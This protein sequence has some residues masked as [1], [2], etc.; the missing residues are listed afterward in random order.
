[1][2]QIPPRVSER[3]ARERASRSDAPPARARVLRARLRIKSCVL[4]VARCKFCA[5]VLMR[6]RVL[7]IVFASKVELWRLR[8]AIFSLRAFVALRARVDPT[9]AGASARCIFCAP[10]LRAHLWSEIVFRKLGLSKWT[11]PADVAK[12]DPN[13]ELKNVPSLLMS[14]F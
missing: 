13:L 9:F 1:M 3:R 14:H 2:C 5:C 4:A 6:G 8:G 10:N 7:H 11:W 12:H